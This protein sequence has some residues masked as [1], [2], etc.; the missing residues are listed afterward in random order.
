MFQI[1]PCS[2]AYDSELIRLH[3]NVFVALMVADVILI[4][5]LRIFT[6]FFRN[7]HKQRVDDLVKNQVIARDSIQ[8]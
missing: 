5:M 1:N 3:R 2:F 7:H 8:V 6:L 4:M